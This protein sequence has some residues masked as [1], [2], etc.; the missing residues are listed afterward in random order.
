[1]MAYYLMNQNARK[2]QSPMGAFA[3]NFSAGMAPDPMS[4]GMGGGD[5]WGMIGDFLNGRARKS[6]YDKLNG[7]EAKS[8]VAPDDVANL[9]DSVWGAYSP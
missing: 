4:G 8:G 2:P 6:K 3:Q 9:A 5:M 1:M 7:G